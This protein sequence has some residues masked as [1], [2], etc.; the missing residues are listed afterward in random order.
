MHPWLGFAVAALAMAAP[1]VA[2]PALYETLLKLSTTVGESASWNYAGNCVDWG[3]SCN[4]GQLQSPV[5][6]SSAMDDV[7]QPGPLYPS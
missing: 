2:A 5:A 3:G 4:V 7:R 6:L 1:S